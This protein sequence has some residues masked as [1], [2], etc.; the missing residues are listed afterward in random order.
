MPPVPEPLVPLPRFGDSDEESL[1]LLRN[2]GTKCYC[3][4]SS[5]YEDSEEDSPESILA[6]DQ[7]EPNNPLLRV[8]EAYYNALQSRPLLIKSITA[9][10][11]MGWADLIAQMVEHW[12]EL[13]PSEYLVDWIRALRFAIFGLVGAPWTHYYYNWLDMVLPPTPYPWTMTTAGKPVYQNGGSRQAKLQEHERL[14]HT[15]ARLLGFPSYLVCRNDDPIWLS[16]DGAEQPR[17]STFI[18]NVPCCC[19][20]LSRNYNSESGD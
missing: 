13:L 12:R 16:L 6:I 17:S 5:S 2:I 4:L 9:L 20:S 10:I 7:H 1:L 3:Y 18:S 19:C 8:W 15:T 11:L 14:E